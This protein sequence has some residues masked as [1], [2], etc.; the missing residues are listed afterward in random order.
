MINDSKQLSNAV[1]L[2]TTV[3]FTLRYLQSIVFLKYRI[4]VNYSQYDLIQSLSKIF[5]SFLSYGRVLGV[6]LTRF[7]VIGGYSC[8]FNDPRRLGIIANIS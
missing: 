6:V 3:S 7:I 8:K 5:R 2:S 4:I 1:T